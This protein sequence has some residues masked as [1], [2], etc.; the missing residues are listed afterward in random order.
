MIRYLFMIHRW[1]LIALLCASTAY[2]AITLKGDAAASDNETFSFEI[3][4]AVPSTLPDTI[5]AHVYTAAAPSTGGANIVKDYSVSQAIR[6]SV[7]IVPLCPETATVNFDKN[8]TNP[9]YDK[10][11]AYMSLFNGFESSL[12]GSNERPVVVLQEDKKTIYV[13][14]SYSSIGQ[15]VHVISAAKSDLDTGL[16]SFIQNV[17]DAAG[18]ITSGIV[19]IE[20]ANP[21]IFAAVGPE[22]GLFGA[23][24]SGIVMA[25]AGTVPVSGEKKAFTG[26]LIADA[27][28]GELAISGGNKATPLN[29]SSDQLK[30]GSNLASLGTI[31]DMH[32][33]R[34]AGRLYI[35]LQATGGAAGTDGTRSIVMARVD[36][37]TN[38]LVISEIAP[39]AA[40]TG[41]DTIVGGVGSSLEVTAH[42]VCGMYTSTALSYLIVQGNVGAPSNTHRS[43]FAL[44]IATNTGN[45]AT[46]G[47]IANKN[48]D[49]QNFF[50]D[51]R[52][53]LFTMRAFTKPAATHADLPFESDA[54]ARVGGGDIVAGDIAHIFVYQDAVFAS[55]LT[56]DAGYEPGVFFSQPLFEYNGKIKGWTQ[57]KRAVG[58]SQRTLNTFIDPVTGQFTSLVG[59]NS[60]EIKIIKR[61]IWSSGDPA[62]LA[63]MIEQ[64]GL[65]F[66]QSEAGVQGVCDFTL[67][68][69]ISGDS[70]P[71]LYD[72]SVTAMTGLNG[73]FLAQTSFINNGIITPVQGGAF[74]TFL[75]FSNGTINETFPTSHSRMIGI[76]GGV[77]DEIGPL[78]TSEFARDGMAGSQGWLF[79]GGSH[80]VAVLS[81]ENGSG[82]DA[83]SKLS[84]GF[85]GL[86]AGMS[87]KK[88]GE[89]VNVRRII[90]DGDYL[91]VL[92]NTDLTRINLT[93][94]TPG[95]G[96]I[97]KV[98]ID[99]V[100]SF[101][102]LGSGSSFLD[103]VVSEKLIILATNAGLFRLNNGLDGRIVNE[104]SASW[105]KLG[106]PE[107]AGPVQ[108]FFPITTTG[109]SQDIAR[110]SVGGTL[111][112][113]SAYR[114]KDQGQLF[115]FDIANVVGK[116]ISDSTVRRLDDL[117]VEGRE[118]YFAN[119]GMF[120]YRCA[121]DGS[122]FYAIQSKNQPD[123]SSQAVAL[124]SKV[125]IQTGSRFMTNKVIP[126]QLE[127]STILS[128]MIQNSATGTWLIAGDI[129]I[130]ANE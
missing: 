108:S 95:L 28:S 85:D 68:S 18:N 17:P 12:K 71:G 21:Y 42:E 57:W 51:R 89:F 126:A 119:F 52:N 118:S 123:T 101:E 22:G 128:G 32:W 78:T 116:S 35:A 121:T 53:K 91:Y 8:V 7:A 1:V 13:I 115:R 15:N 79:V 77:L 20:A 88:C 124:F 83:T 54:A 92:T 93:E 64:L 38:A 45:E 86:T 120:Q 40:F 25:V 72:I 73:V 46:I 50:L 5:G 26:L 130:R 82:W 48:D 117:Y 122:L 43:V 29:I 39:A 65:F 109:I 23:T 110:S 74:G 19:Q 37:K 14:N 56:A 49:P 94:G 62:S 11:I 129:G 60:N 75:N 70:Y 36:S 125:G 4:Q 59:N 103:M 16:L 41:T 98:I 58:L 127:N 3:Q 87:F 30:I 76:K 27:P 44:P 55:V 61:T 6:E 107:G 99:T 47:M 113:L 31:V 114:G 10:G 112:V 100:S 66:P 104:Q 34:A 24:G 106:L 67:S 105:I 80:G 90:H 2:S 111:Y 97:S 63:P 69:T 9:L 81:S 84:D 33:H 96:I 102:Q